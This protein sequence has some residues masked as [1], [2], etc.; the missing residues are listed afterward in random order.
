MSVFG[1]FCGFLDNCLSVLTIV[2][3]FGQLSVCLGNCVGVWK[4]VW[5]FGQLCGFLDNCL[6]LLVMASVYLHLLCILLF[7]SY[8]FI[9]STEY[10]KH[11]TYSPFLS[12]QN[13]VCFIILTYLVP[14]LCTFYI[15]S[16]LKFK[17]SNSGAKLLNIFLEYCCVI[18]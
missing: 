14:A 8:S 9:P 13:A 5:V 7:R 2:W 3:V 1:Q 11:C 16:V 18:D 10:F 15:Q 6:R 17:K 12:L 4:I